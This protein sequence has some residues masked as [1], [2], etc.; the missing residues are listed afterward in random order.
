MSEISKQLQEEKQRTES[1]QIRSERSTGYF[2]FYNPQ[3]AKSK[4]LGW[5]CVFGLVA[6]LIYLITNLINE[7]R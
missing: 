2:A 3:K 1:S 4:L 6:I 7:V 5:S